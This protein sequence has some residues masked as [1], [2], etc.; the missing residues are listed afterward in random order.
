MSCQFLDSIEHLKNIRGNYPVKYVPT[1]APILDQPCFAEN[2]Q[3]LR[4][5]R[6]AKTQVSLHVANTL[7]SILQ[8]SQNS[9]PYRVGQR[10]ENLCLQMVW[11]CI[12]YFFRHNIH[13][14][15]YDYIPGVKGCQGRKRSG[16]PSIY[17]EY[18]SIIRRL[19]KD[20]SAADG[21]EKPQSAGSVP[22]GLAPPRSS[23]LL[24]R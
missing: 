6:L 3:L 12:N 8:N 1:V 20:L 5:I 4:K 22:V 23:C 10:L 19:F 11:L 2:R 7:F 15:E 9:Q 13:Y 17:R 21:L 16:Q 14:L 24:Y 18:T